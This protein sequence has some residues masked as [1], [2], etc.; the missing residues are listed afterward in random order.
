MQK[1]PQGL[2][3]KFSYHFSGPLHGF[4]HLFDLRYE[5]YNFAT[6]NKY[7]VNF[8]LFFN[9]FTNEFCEYSKNSN[10]KRIYLNLDNFTPLTESEKD[11]QTHNE[12]FNNWTIE[13]TKT[14]NEL[15]SRIMYIRP[16]M[17]LTQ[18]NLTNIF[19][20]LKLDDDNNLYEISDGQW[21]TASYVRL[22][23]L[24]RVGFDTTPLTQID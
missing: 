5:R 21:I 10:S 2:V 17:Y 9:A 6:K 1:L 16:R 4:Y 23:E 14:I 11:F 24:E 20:Y 13:L 8:S 19:P 3:L 15:I 22:K 7:W 18:E 12:N